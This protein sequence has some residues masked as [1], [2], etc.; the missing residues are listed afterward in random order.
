MFAR[1]KKQMVVYISSMLLETLIVM[2]LTGWA[3][4]M[5]EVC[6]SIRSTFVAPCA[7]AD[8]ESFVH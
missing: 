1:V 6:P 4:R 8:T 2:V 3:D 7:G 5:L